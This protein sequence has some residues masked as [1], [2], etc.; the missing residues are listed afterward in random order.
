MQNIYK[1]LLPDWVFLNKNNDLIISE[2][3]NKYMQRYPEYIVIKVEKGFAICERNL[4][5]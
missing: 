1:V 2:N 5:V 4:N 3:L